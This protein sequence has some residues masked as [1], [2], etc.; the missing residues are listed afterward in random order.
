MSI[1]WRITQIAWQHRTRLLL[2]YLTFFIAIF[3]SLAIPW[4]L[5]DAVDKLVVTSEMVEV[6]DGEEQVTQVIEPVADFGEV[7]TVL[8]WLAGALLVFSIFRGL[9]DFARTYLTD[10]LSQMVSSNL[11]NQL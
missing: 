4:I 9:F 5:G 1:L 11:R 6:V 10:S 7:R 2:A 8:L 3:F